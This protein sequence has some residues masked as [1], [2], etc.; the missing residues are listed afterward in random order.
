MH[1]GYAWR[2]VK[3]II[4]EGERIHH[5]LA[6]KLK[7]MVTENHRLELTIPSSIPPGE[8]EIIL[9]FPILVFGKSLCRFPANTP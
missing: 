6:V 7:G 2:D 4:L 9:T 1:R 5:M 8:V 3:A